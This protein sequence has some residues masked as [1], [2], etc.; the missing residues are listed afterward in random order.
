MRTTDY[1]NQLKDLCKC[2]VHIT[3]NGHKDSYKD[4]ECYLEF[5]GLDGDDVSPEVLDEMIKKDTV[6]EVQYYPNTPVGFLNVY[7]YDLESALKEAVES[8]GGKTQ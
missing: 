8:L 4:V 2:G 7:H 3:I 6:I 1:L 5:P